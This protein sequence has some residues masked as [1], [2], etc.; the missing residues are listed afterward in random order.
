VNNT[1]AKKRLEEKLIS[2]H[3]PSTAIASYP[4]AHSFSKNNGILV[5]VH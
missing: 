5:A 1:K 2:D 3:Y 4:I